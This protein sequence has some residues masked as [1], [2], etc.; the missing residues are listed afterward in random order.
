MSDRVLS[1]GLTEPFW[2]FFEVYAKL[3]PHTDEKTDPCSSKPLSRQGGEPDF[4]SFAPISWF[5]KWDQLGTCR[6][7]NSQASTLEFV[8]Q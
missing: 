1:G 8:I 6:N 5:S 3:P 7:A 4:R 2:H